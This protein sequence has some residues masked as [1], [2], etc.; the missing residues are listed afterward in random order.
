MSW[1]SRIAEQIKRFMVGRYGV[2]QLSFALLIFSM[3]V[4]FAASAARWPYLNILSWL[5]LLLM[6]WRMLSTNISRRYSENQRFLKIYRPAADFIKERV[7]I[8]KDRDH[9]YCKC[10]RCR[11][12]IRVPRGRGRI[13]ITCPKCRI[14]FTKK[15]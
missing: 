10:P 15:T 1:L 3:I 11:Q 13:S 12:K 6:L 7:R 5:L 4:T 14:Q 9:K 2:D 8:L